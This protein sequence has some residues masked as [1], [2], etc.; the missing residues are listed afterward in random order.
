MLALL[1]LFLHLHHAGVKWTGIKAF[2]T[3]PDFVCGGG[4]CYERLS[5]MIVGGKDNM[6]Q[7][8]VVTV[9]T[10]LS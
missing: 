5:K 4:R 7:M 6:L 10:K 9:P 8:F 2:E 1:Q 3:L